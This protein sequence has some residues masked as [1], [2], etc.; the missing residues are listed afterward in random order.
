MKELIAFFPKSSWFRMSFWLFL[1]QGLVALSTYALIRASGLAATD[2]AA[3]SPWVLVFLFALSAPYVPGIFGRREL[4]SGVQSA[5]RNF[6]SA[7]FPADGE[8]IRRWARRDQRETFLA[9]VT[10]E[11]LGQLRQVA[12]TVFDITAVLLNV[13]LNLAVL[14]YHF[15]PV[16]AAA[17]ALGTGVAFLIFRRM[18]PRID[19]VSE[20]AQVS[21]TALFAKLQR[22]WDNM[23]AAHAVHRGAFRMSLDA[24]LGRHRTKAMDAVTLSE[25]VSV[26]TTFAILTP[27]LVSVVVLLQMN[28]TAAFLAS[29]LAT[30][31]RQFQVM[32]NLQVFLSYMTAL[33]G[34][35][36]Q[37]RQVLAQ[38]RIEE[39]RTEDFVNLDQLRLSFRRESEGE[40][41]A[42]LGAREML[43]GRLPAK[44][45]LVV[46]GPNGAGK[47][48]LLLSLKGKLGDGA[49]YL[50]AHS[51]FWVETEN[52]TSSS[53][54]KILR[55]LEFAEKRGL[56]PVILLDEWDANLDAENRARIADRLEAL[57]GA[58]L[59]VEVRHHA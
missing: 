4:E 49:Y 5:Y 48:S 54:E 25:L 42:A 30:L 40:V 6:L 45:R 52:R 12:A 19:A 9:S 33:T 47:S 22:S 46:R 1:E 2:V 14:G 11:A 16:I 56:P 51:D 26:G 55:T 7:N 3:A 44:G 15:H 29:M 8:G 31:P 39:L 58:H 18:L 50:P 32:G 36:A 28:P 38:C 34:I 20:E 24:D 17:F 41:V 59:I 53:G 35:S 43:A 21:R 10:G 13:T 37:A 27:V 57:A 23:F